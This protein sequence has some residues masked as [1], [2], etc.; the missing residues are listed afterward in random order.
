MIGPNH[1]IFQPPL[2]DEGL[3]NPLPEARFDPIG[4]VLGPNGPGLSVVVLLLDIIC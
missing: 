4:P 1:P 3:W 2:S